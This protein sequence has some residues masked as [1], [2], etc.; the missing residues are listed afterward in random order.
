MARWCRTRISSGVVDVLDELATETGK[1]VPQISLR[2]LFAEADRG[3][4]M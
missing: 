3:P 4:R 2:W 1:T